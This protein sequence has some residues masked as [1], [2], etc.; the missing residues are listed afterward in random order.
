MDAYTNMSY[1]ELVE[2]QE[3]GYN[4]AL[5]TRY[6]ATRELFLRIAISAREELTV[7]NK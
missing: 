2:L 1:S 6:T 7:R 3:V 5:N 4:A